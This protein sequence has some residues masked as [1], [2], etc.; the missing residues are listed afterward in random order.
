MINNLDING[1]FNIFNRDVKLQNINDKN[2]KNNTQAHFM[3][4]GQEFKINVLSMACGA[5]KEAQTY[6]TPPNEHGLVHMESLNMGLNITTIE[7]FQAIFLLISCKADISLKITTNN[8]NITQNFDKISL[9][10]FIICH[11]GGLTIFNC[12]CYINYYGRTHDVY[13]QD[14]PCG[15]VEGSIGN[16][17]DI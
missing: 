10:N 4:D 3:V 14:K 5:K 2:T 6:G 7:S 1:Y 16:A 8:E 12:S 13:E 15:I 11:S 9:G 17:I